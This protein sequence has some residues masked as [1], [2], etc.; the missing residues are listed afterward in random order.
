MLIKKVLNLTKINMWGSRFDLSERCIPF[1]LHED[2]L[3]EDT[4]TTHQDT[5]RH[6]LRCHNNHGESVPAYL[7]SIFFSNFCTVL[8]T[9]Y[10][11]LHQSA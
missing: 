11:T 3:S 10:N 7:Q 5:V 9:V 1:D 4:Q 2:K 8:K 6:S